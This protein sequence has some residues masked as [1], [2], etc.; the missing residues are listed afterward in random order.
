M[1]EHIFSAEYAASLVQRARDGATFHHV[2]HECHNGEVT[3]MCIEHSRW[4]PSGCDMRD[5]GFHWV[6]W[7]R[8]LAASVCV[9]YELAGAEYEWSETWRLLEN[10]Q[11][12]FLDSLKA[13]GSLCQL[14]DEWTAAHRE[15]ARR[16]GGAT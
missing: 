6:E 13:L 8:E 3:G 7:Y 11:D 15:E 4:W 10:L 12:D 2:E 9:A 1:T 16:I 5:R 14:P